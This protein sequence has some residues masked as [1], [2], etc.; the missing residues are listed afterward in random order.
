MYYPKP[1]NDHSGMSNHIAYANQLSELKVWSI[2][3]Q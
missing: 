2:L 3:Q 1:R